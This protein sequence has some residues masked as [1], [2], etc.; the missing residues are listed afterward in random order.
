MLYLGQSV[1]EAVDARRLHH[2]LVPMEIKYED[3]VTK[4]RW[5]VV[6]II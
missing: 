6:N 2:Q 1:K 5:K 3:G 4:V